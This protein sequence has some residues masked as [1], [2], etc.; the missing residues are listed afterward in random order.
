MLK[1]IDYRLSALVRLSKKYNLGMGVS[2]VFPLVLFLYQSLDGNYITTADGR[3]HLAWFRRLPFHEHFKN[4]YIADFYLTSNY[5]LFNA[6]YRIPSALGVDPLNMAIVYVTL[7][8]VGAT[9]SVY[10]FAA[11]ADGSRLTAMFT[12]VFFSLWIWADGHISSG[13]ARSFGW[14]G[15]LAFLALFSGRRY[16][17]AGVVLII[18]SLIYPPTVMMCLGV[19][20]IYTVAT[21][22]PHDL[23]TLKTVPARAALA[24]GVIGV[25]A[26][27]PNLLTHDAF[28]PVIS[29]GEARTLAEATEAGRRPFF[30]SSRADFWIFATRSGLLNRLSFDLT[31]VILTAVS[32]LFLLWRARTIRPWLVSLIVTGIGLWAVAHLLLFRLYLPGRYPTFLL[33]VAFVLAAGACAGRIVQRFDLPAGLALLMPPLALIPATVLGQYP[34]NN[35]IVATTPRIFDALKAPGHPGTVAGVGDAVDQTPIF[36]GRSVVAASLFSFWYKKAYHQEHSLRSAAT[37]ASVSNSTP[38]ALLALS[39][40]MQ[41]AAWVVDLDF[42]TTGVRGAYAA[43]WVKSIVQEYRIKSF[44]DREQSWLRRQTGCIAVLQNGHA[45]YWTGCLRAAAKRQG[46]A[47]ADRHTTAD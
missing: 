6:L 22:R 21:E 26:L 2:I 31:L 33:G 38:G 36:S 17:W 24:I 13:T 34:A 45:L 1:I 8:A 47:V 46:F 14:A 23:M 20:A 4:D 29:G 37:I 3:Q 15:L 9:V 43:R 7:I 18:S 12:A 42:F 16:V 5:P 41:V 30:L 28:G 32:S 25:A 10:V 44:A 40:R 27:L 11:R 35:M 39:D 19:V